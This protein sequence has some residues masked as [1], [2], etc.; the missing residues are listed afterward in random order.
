MLLNAATSLA[1]PTQFQAGVQMMRK[2]KA[3]NGLQHIF[4]HSNLWSSVFTGVAIIANRVTPS[5]RDQSGRPQ[6][7]DL[8]VSSGTDS[9]SRLILS[10]IGAD[11]RYCPGDVCFV[12]GAVLQHAV[13]DWDEGNRLA[14]A[15]YHRAN[16]AERMAIPA[17]ASPFIQDFAPM[18]APDFVER[19]THIYS[20]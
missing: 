8:L 1:A 16:V 11:I 19:H 7:Y 2:A 13:L 10:D 5:H 14:Y 4:K 12:S 3:G 9:Q 17:G 6:W 18:M 15:Q 20:H